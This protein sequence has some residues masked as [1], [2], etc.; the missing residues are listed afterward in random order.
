M[1]RNEDNNRLATRRR[2][3]VCK[4]SVM[5]LGNNPRVFGVPDVS[6]GA[7]EVAPSAP[8]AERLPVHRSARNYLPSHRMVKETMLRCLPLRLT[9]G[10]GRAAVASRFDD[11][12]GVG[13]GREISTE[14]HL[15]GTP[16]S[17]IEAALSP[18]Y[19]V[20]PVCSLD[21]IMGAERGMVASNGSFFLMDVILNRELVRDIKEGP[22][23]PDHV[24]MASAKSDEANLLPDSDFKYRTLVA[25]L[26]G[27][28]V[29]Y[30]ARERRPSTVGLP[31]TPVHHDVS[32]L[33]IMEDRENPP[34][35]RFSFGPGGFVRQFSAEFATIASPTSRATHW[36]CQRQSCEGPSTLHCRGT[37]VS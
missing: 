11:A 31:N 4:S 32:W 29:F 18:S 36:V 12:M 22:R 35:A 8:T 13:R 14:R 10:E 34:G 15:C 33:R 16:L 21:D 37:T 3:S 23:D 27:A 17:W 7:A 5:N 9:H 1:F 24:V 20:I 30:C 19:D 6:G 2:S 25:Y 26:P 28:G